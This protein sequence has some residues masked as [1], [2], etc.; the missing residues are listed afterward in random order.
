MSFIFVME[1]MFG[2]IVSNIC[3][4]LLVIFTQLSN[5]NQWTLWQ[6]CLVAAKYSQ[7]MRQITELFFIL[8]YNAAGPI[9]GLRPLPVADVRTTR[10]ALVAAAAGCAYVSDADSFTS[11]DELTVG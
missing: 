6:V 1:V 5:Q 10:M 11:D 3:D 9:N 7:K 2:A 8:E 4:S